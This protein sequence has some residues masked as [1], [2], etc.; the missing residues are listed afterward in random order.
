[1]GYSPYSEHRPSAAV[2]K[3]R[4]VEHYDATDA[5]AAIDAKAAA[6][7]EGYAQGLRNVY[8]FAL[9]LAVLALLL[10]LALPSLPLRKK[11]EAVPAAAPSA[12]SSAS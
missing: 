10:T 6:L 5:D 9:A 1:M 7:K 12:A 11:G 2:G 4:R 3:V 8:R